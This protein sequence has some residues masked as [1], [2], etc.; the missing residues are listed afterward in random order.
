MINEQTNKCDNEKATFIVGWGGELHKC[1][2]EH[3]YQLQVLGNVI[4]SPTD[5]QP[6][7]TNEKC[8]MSENKED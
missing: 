1:C 7:F 8:Y 3:A 5:K 4:G 6:I 2:D